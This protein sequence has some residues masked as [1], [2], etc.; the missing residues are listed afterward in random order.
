MAVGW[1]TL[2]MY[3]EATF[4]EVPNR[5]KEK[6]RKVLLVWGLDENGNP[7]KKEPKQP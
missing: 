4:E 5:F 2:I 3:G 7:I 1:A 6:V